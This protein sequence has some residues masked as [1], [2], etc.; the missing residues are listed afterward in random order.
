M[1]GKHPSTNLIVDV[2][3]DDF[4]GVRAMVLDVDTKQQR[5]SLGLKAS[6]F[7]GDDDED[8]GGINEVCQSSCTSFAL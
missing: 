7:S 3:I 6:Y 1:S 4:A 2:M 5:L 8:E